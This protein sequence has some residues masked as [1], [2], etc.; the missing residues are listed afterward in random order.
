MLTPLVFLLEQVRW[1][2]AAAREDERGLTTTEMVVITALLVTLAFAAVAI[3]SNAVLN[4][5]HSINL[6]GTNP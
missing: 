6:E 5:A 4:K 3:I 1:R 2:V